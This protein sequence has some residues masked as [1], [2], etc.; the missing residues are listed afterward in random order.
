MFLLLFSHFLAEFLLNFIACSL[1]PEE[2]IDV[3]ERAF[4]GALGIYKYSIECVRRLVFEPISS[5][6]LNLLF[7]FILFDKIFH[8]VSPVDIY[9]YPSNPNILVSISNEHRLI[10]RGTTKLQHC[11]AWLNLQAFYRDRTRVVHTIKNT[12]LIE[13]TMINLCLRVY[14]PKIKLDSNHFFNL[15][16]Q[17]YCYLFC[18][19]L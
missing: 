12:F 18:S 5:H 16:T 7:K 1:L 10:A 8:D 15:Q 13:L 4:M 14:G 2:F 9:F 6:N 17:F 3:F 19:Y 11:I